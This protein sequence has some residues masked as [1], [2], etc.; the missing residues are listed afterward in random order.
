MKIFLA[1]SFHTK[2]D[3]NRLEKIFNLLNDNGYE[4]WWAPRKVKRGY[5]SRDSGL[6]KK[7]NDTEEDA[8]EKS[9]LLVAVMKRATFGTAFEIKHAFDHWIPI[10][11]YLLEYHLDFSS[12]SF[13]H[14]V[15]DIVRTDEELLE[16]IKR[17][18]K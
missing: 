16:A 15:K 3:E 9:D 10:I 6:I 17:H 8:I 4:I 7:I 11:G 2:K 14:R 18:E 1:G 5:G 12:G 13:N